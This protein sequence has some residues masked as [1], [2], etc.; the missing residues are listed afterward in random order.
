MVSGGSILS[1]LTTLM[2]DNQ[3]PLE[4][5]Y[6][7]GSLERYVHTLRLFEKHGCL[8]EPQQILDIGICP[9]HLAAI[10]AQTYGHRV[11]GITM[12]I[13]D[14]FIARMK[15]CGVHIL[16]VDVDRCPVPFASNTFDTILFTETIEH[17]FN[18]YLVLEENHR[19]LKPSGL[20]FISTPNLSSLRKRIHFV[21]GKSILPYSKEERGTTFYSDGRNEYRGH[22]REYT[23]IELSLLVQQSGFEI[24]DRFFF[25]FP[26]PQVVT[27]KERILR[28]LAGLSPT[29][30]DRI[31]LAA[32]K[33]A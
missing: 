27:I 32:S 25:S 12:T 31:I 3:F 29:L 24:I 16:Q 1:L 20:L 23:A 18:P 10:L 6:L 8:N 17:L 30:Q 4:E 7:A 11:I 15:Q 26:L 33:G 5:E 21:Q 14:G 13:W 2:Q 28:L 19:V 9:G 22:L